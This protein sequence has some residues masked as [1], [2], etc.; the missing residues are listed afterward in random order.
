MSF[1]NF[2][3][4]GDRTYDDIIGLADSGPGTIYIQSGETI[5]YTT[6]VNG[7]F[8][9]TMAYCR[10]P[11][12]P[13]NP[14]GIQPRFD[15][16]TGTFIDATMFTDV[17]ASEVD[18]GRKWVQPELDSS[19]P[20]STNFKGRVELGGTDGERCIGVS[21][22]GETQGSADLYNLISIQCTGIAYV[23]TFSTT[24]SQRDLLTSS[25]SNGF[26]LNS[27]STASSADFGIAVSEFPSTESSITMLINATELK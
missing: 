6:G 14:N 10:N 4:F 2:H 21:W 1:Q 24:Y 27:G 13:S 9:S 11:L 25:S 26:V 3:T 7:A 17:S 23:K 18:V 16:P 19:A 22:N 20:E 8:Q 12:A 5:F 15:T